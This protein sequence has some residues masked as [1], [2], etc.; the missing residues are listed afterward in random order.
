MI[1]AGTISTGSGRTGG[2]GRRVLDQLDQA[3]AVDDLARR[4]RHLVPD[5]E[6]LGSHRPAAGRHALPVLEEVL[7]AADEVHAHFRPRALDDFGIEER[8]VRRREDVEPLARAERD[9]LLVLRVHA[10]D[11]R[12]RVVPPLLREQEGLVDQIVRE[13]PPRLAEETPVLRQRLDAGLA[14]VSA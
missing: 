6:C 12:R 8:M 11:A 5:P 10:V 2:G 1:H 3:I 7:R 9:D 13:L 4:D 14:A